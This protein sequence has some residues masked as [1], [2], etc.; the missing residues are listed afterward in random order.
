MAS[1]RNARSMRHYSCPPSAS[2]HADDLGRAERREAGRQGDA[3]LDCGSLAVDNPCVEACRGVW[4][5]S[6][7]SLAVTV[8]LT[9]LSENRS[10]RPG[11]TDCRYRCRG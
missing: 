7:A 6:F 9:L 11:N 10:R 3:D 5:V 2:G 8:A 4:R 1:L